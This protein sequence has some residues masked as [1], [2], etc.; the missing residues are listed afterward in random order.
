MNRG[1]ANRKDHGDD[2]ESRDNPVDAEEL[3]AVV[4]A[5]LHTEAEL[6]ESGPV[7]RALTAILAEARP[8]SVEELA[9]IVGRPAEQISAGL[10]GDTE[11][12]DHGR[13]IGR[14]ITLSQ[15]AH[16]LEVD[17]R[18]VYAWCAAAALGQI[19]AI[20]QTVRI[21][22]PCGATGQTVTVVA[23][24]DGVAEVHP[25]EAVVSIVA[26]G[27]PNRVRL[28]R[29]T[30]I[31]FFV[32]AGAASKWL[33]EHPDGTLLTVHDGFRYSKRLAQLLMADH[34]TST[35]DRLDLLAQQV[36]AARHI[37]DPDD[38][39]IALTLLRLLG[40]G[41][42]VDTDQ[43]SEALALPASRIEQTL[44]RW[45]E[46]FRDDEGRVNALMGLSIAEIGEH[47]IHLDRR[48]LSAWCAWDTL[49]LPELLGEPAS[50][51]SRCPTTGE[52]I[53]LHVTRTGPADPSPASIVISFLEPQSA[54]DA[55]VISSFC[56][57]VH[58]FA[59]PRAA[60]AWTGEHP[61]T[62]QLSLDEAWR[63]AWR[64]N[65]ATFGAGLGQAGRDQ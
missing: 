23:G 9:T 39:R 43:L 14:G 13:V 29:C 51:S 55:N 4:A 53:S 2:H 52:R 15:T 58:F 63:L 48:T 5:S 57:Y 18:M 33:R 41:E 38:Q 64:T 32:S 46:A 20:G 10:P 25:P 30:N 34:T 26:G 6:N 3:A 54:F 60:E 31:H 12:D 65:H 50:V 22:S 16:R 44:K 45:P 24:P 62:F 1:Y 8:A 61:G 7:F 11:L 49:F 36:T 28:S 27:D 56:R 37:S 17:G 42:P 59:S 21:S 40:Q 47:R 19:P 35:A